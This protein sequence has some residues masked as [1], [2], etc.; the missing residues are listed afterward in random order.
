M[1]AV[2]GTVVPTLASVE[3]TGNPDAWRAAEFLVGTN[4]AI[5]FGNGAITFGDTPALRVTE[6][7]G[8][9]ELAATYPLIP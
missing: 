8:G 5:T 3:I 7:A 4:G 6:L 9:T 1:N 2:P